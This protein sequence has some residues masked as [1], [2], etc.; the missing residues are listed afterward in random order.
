MFWEFPSNLWFF[1]YKIIITRMI[2]FR[3]GQYPPLVAFCHCWAHFLQVK[4]NGKEDKVHFNL[5]NSQMAEPSVCHV[6]FHLSEDGL[7]FYAPTSSVP[8]SIFR[9]KPLPCF[10]PVS[11]Q[12]VI[13]FDD[14]ASL[15]LE[16]AS[17]E[18]AFLTAPGLV[19]CTV[20]NGISCISRKR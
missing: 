11:V 13:D 1:A 18:R 4:G 17:Q 7:R 6:V 10:S 5:V 14:S 2:W 16:I 12:A 8:D 19:A 15:S 9:D 3:F 20:H